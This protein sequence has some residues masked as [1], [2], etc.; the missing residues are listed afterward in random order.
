MRETEMRDR[1]RDRETGDELD[2]SNDKLDESIRIAVGC[3]GRERPGLIFYQI[4]DG[5]CEP[6]TGPRAR[7]SFQFAGQRICNNAH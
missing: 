2:E 7:G 5:P 1:K 4:E 6:A 3:K